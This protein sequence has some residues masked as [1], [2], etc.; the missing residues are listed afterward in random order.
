ML[1]VSIK[2]HDVST[3]GKR[4]CALREN[5]FPFFELPCGARLECR[6]GVADSAR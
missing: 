5:N 3:G 6:R 1:C 2:L 4:H